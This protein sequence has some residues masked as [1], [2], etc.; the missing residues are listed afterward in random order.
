MDGGES[1]ELPVTFLGQERMVQATLSTRGYL[2]RITAEVD[3]VL[4]F[5]EP[6]EERN[7]R[8]VLAEPTG[9]SSVNTALVK[10]I[11]EALELNFK[12]G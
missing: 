1:F 9:N 6:D 4:V 2:H 7:Y 12:N 8:A 3:G 10:A 5:F 11:V